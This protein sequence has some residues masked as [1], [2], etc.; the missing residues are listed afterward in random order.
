MTVED[1]ATPVTSQSDSRGDEKSQRRE[2]TLLE[3]RLL[4]LRLVADSEYSDGNDSREMS[5]EPSLCMTMKRWRPPRPATRLPRRR[6]PV[7]LE[8]TD[9]PSSKSIVSI[10]LISMPGSLANVDGSRPRCDDR[11]DLPEVTSTDSRWSLWPCDDDTPPDEAAAA[12]A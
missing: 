6:P 2:L 10:R 3:A 11:D 12:A 9:E 8:N 4:R 5:L 1:D 7:V